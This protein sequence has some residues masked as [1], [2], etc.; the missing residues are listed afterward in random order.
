MRKLCNCVLSAREPRQVARPV[1]KELFARVKKDICEVVGKAVM[2][3][4]LKDMKDCT[5]LRSYSSAC[6]K[7]NTLCE[8]GLKL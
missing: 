1:G 7:I 4:E 3:M 5:H 6:L 2:H 8:K